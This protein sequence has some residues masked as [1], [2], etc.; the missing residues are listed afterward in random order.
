MWTQ[1]SGEYIINFISLLIISIFLVT[2]W[3]GSSR[4]GQPP[5]FDRTSVVAFHTRSCSCFRH[6]RTLSPFMGVICEQLKWCGNNLALLG[7]AGWTTGYGGEV[8]AL[9]RVRQLDSS[10]ASCLQER[11]RGSELYGATSET[12]AARWERQEN[13]P[14]AAHRGSCRWHRHSHTLAEPTRDFFTN[15]FQSA[16]TPFPGNSCGCKFWSY[17][18]TFSAAP[19]F[20]IR[21]T[22]ALLYNTLFSFVG[23]SLNVSMFVNTLVIFSYRVKG[24]PQV[25][26][27]SS[28]LDDIVTFV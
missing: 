5:P 20:F 13:A 23:D 9:P 11:G 19:G 15:A 10:P 2:L 18:G 26:F 22:K 16:S 1:L 24:N 27:S 21:F 25:I 14:L 4:C 8:C 3:F 7:A 17:R 12:R 28:Q 6:W